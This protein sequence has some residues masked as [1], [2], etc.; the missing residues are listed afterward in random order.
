MRYKGLAFLLS[1]V[2]ALAFAG[3]Q[4]ARAAITTVNVDGNYSDWDSIA[5]TSIGSSN[6]AITGTGN[7]VYFYV[8]ASKQSSA[9]KLSD[10]HVKI[11]SYT[12]KISLS[13][14]GENY[15]LQGQDQQTG[16]SATLG[17]IGAAVVKNNK[18]EAAIDL[19][20]L[21]ETFNGMQ[22]LTILNDSIGSG[23]ATS[24]D[25]VSTTAATDLANAVTMPTLDSG[26]ATEIKDTDAD[27]SDVTSA[28]SGMVTSGIT[29]DG[30]DTDWNNVAKIQTGYSGTNDVAVTTDSNHVYF[31]VNGTNSTSPVATNSYTLTIGGNGYYV[32]L[33][34]NGDGTYNVQAQDQSNSWVQLGTIGT[35]TIKNNVLEAQI[36]LS[37]LPQKYS[38]MQ[39]VSLNNPQ[40][41][42]G[43]ATNTGDLT[44]NALADA[45]AATTVTPIE[46]VQVSDT[47]T[48]AGSSSTSSASSSSA[49]SLS[50]TSSHAAGSSDTDVASSSSETAT[51]DA[52]DATSDTKSSDAKS[53]D[54]ISIDG[55]YSDWTNVAKTA[56][57][58]WQTDDVAM[59]NDGTNVYFYY[60]ASGANAQK[61]QD[62]WQDNFYILVGNNRYP[63]KLSGT[64]GEVT[65]S[66][67]GKVVGSAVVSGDR[68]EASVPVSDL[69]LNFDASGQTVS[70]GNYK[71]A[72]DT[73]STV[74][75][76]DITNNQVTD[77]TK[78][79]GSSSDSS[80]SS[81]ST[82][83]D[84]NEDGTSNALNQAVSGDSSTDSSGLKQTN[85]T[86]NDLNIKIDG[87]FDDWRDK[88]L[89]PMQIN[90]DNDNIKP[91]ALLADDKYVYFYISQTPFWQG[92]YLNLQPDGYTLNVG[93]TAYTIWLNNHQTVNLASGTT[94]KISVGVMDNKTFKTI[95][96]GG[97]AYVGAR[98]I[99]QHTGTGDTEVDGTGYQWEVR[100]PLSE[101]GGSSTV[102][103]QE[104]TLDNTNLWD[105]ELKASGGSTGPVVL[106]SAGFLIAAITVLK[107]TG[108][109][110]KK[111]WF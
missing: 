21:P 15:I 73:V 72:G 28:V 74:I 46:K 1:C 87:N 65:V 17:N 85:N 80:S 82:T 23:E 51:T 53:T 32:S 10:Y 58:Y 94:Q 100:I 18:I 55:D 77:A 5:K 8:D 9:V 103:G 83:S 106:A 109:K 49:G 102:D 78:E 56:M 29:I 37:D 64:S 95:D 13:G 2:G 81:D 60:D 67:N 26:E 40:V 31:Y 41:G 43:T 24:L 22:T 92:G 69:G 98:T 30:N 48:T 88:T 39:T 50:S 27:S 33:I 105:G 107:T 11:G 36:N 20:K 63:V 38:G 111:R 101:L 62:T 57:G 4:S 54:G 89:S 66:V 104:I 19:T 59:T 110:L 93:S 68:V 25:S 3:S 90:G 45:A 7:H 52:E 108:F 35:A 70:V 16:S 91:S 79:T 12:Y 34:G 75:N 84:V 44:T 6:M 14:S 96:D 42:P 61:F 71:V 97:D 99:T 76:S 47:Y 86:S